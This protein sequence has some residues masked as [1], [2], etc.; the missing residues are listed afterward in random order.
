MG[1]ASMARVYG[2]RWG[3]QVSSGGVWDWV[4]DPHAGK[5]E[6]LVPESGA[7]GAEVSHVVM[8]LKQL[9]SLSSYGPLVSIYG[10]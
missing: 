7:A 3:W 4:R 1:Q 2:A 6:T 9:W 8:A 5:V 10:P